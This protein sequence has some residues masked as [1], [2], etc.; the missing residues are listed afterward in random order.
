[1]EQSKTFAQLFKKYR[2]K[3]EF[4]TLA[5]FANALAEEGKFYEESLFSHWQK[6]T[7]MPKNRELLIKVINIF[8]KRG[9]IYTLQEANEFLTSA[10]QGHLSD[11]E[12][13]ELPD[14][15]ILDHSKFKYISKFIWNS[16]KTEFIETT[17]TSIWVATPDFY[18]NAKDSMWPQII[19][20]N[21]IK[22]TKNYYLYKDTLEGR[23]NLSLII[24]N[25]EKKLN[26][27]WQKLT[28]YIPVDPYNFPWYLEHVLYNPYDSND[29]HCIAIG[30]IGNRETIDGYNIELIERLRFDFRKKFKK[31][32]NKKVT[33]PYWKI[34]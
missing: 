7:R 15:E 4:E 34:P 24:S 9:G 23:E 16:E 3:S 32:W 28:H 30:L 22:G 25:L 26:S 5:D 29:E 21:I 10:G 14:S 20:N 19:L 18:W 6:G 27:D 8:V 12:I 17:A 31:I 33:E 13:C 1:M 2:L 11:K